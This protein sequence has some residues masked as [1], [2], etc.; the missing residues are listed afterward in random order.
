MVQSCTIS[1]DN[2]V[3]NVDLLSLLLILNN[4]ENFPLFWLLKLKI[5]LPA[6]LMGRGE[7]I[8]DLLLTTF[9]IT[10]SKYLF[11]KT[12][13]NVEASLSKNWNKCFHKGT[14]P[15][16]F[17]GCSFQIKAK[18]YPFK[19]TRMTAPLIAGNFGGKITRTRQKNVTQHKL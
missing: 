1:T 3:I 12:K 2:E 14:L 10:N 8:V 9:Q 6:C 18:L 5:F 7:K 13:I 17:Y 4:C 16:L 15:G 19:T 11:Q